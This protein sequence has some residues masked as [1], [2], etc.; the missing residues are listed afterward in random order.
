M[1]PRPLAFGALAGNYQSLPPIASRVRKKKRP[2]MQ[3]ETMLSRVRGSEQRFDSLQVLRGANEVGAIADGAVRALLLIRRGVRTSRSDQGLV[4]ARSFIEDLAAQ[5][6]SPRRSSANLKISKLM[7]LSANAGEEA[8]TVQAGAPQPDARI[9]E[10]LLRI[11]ALLADIQHGSE[12][13]GDLD[14]ALATFDAL[15]DATHEA[16]SNEFRAHSG[17]PQWSST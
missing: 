17:H 6:R 2:N 12:R 8:S 10:E 5:T 9:R 4:H 11:A 14:R 13:D 15:A 7:T 16:A 3:G 1:L